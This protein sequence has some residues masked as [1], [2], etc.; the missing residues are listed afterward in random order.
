ME[1]RKTKL[2]DCYEIVP[3]RFGDSRGYFTPYYIKENMEKEGLDKIFGEIVQCNRSLSSKGTLRGLHFQLDPYCQSKVVEV[4]SGKA[5]DV[6]VD[7][8]TNSSTFG[9]N[10]WVLL[11]PIVGNQLLVPKGFAHGF[12]A[13]EDNT[14]FQYLVDNKYAP[15]YEDGITWNDEELGINWNEWF[16]KYN[17]DKPLLSDKDLKM[18]TLSLK[19]KKGN[20]KF[21]R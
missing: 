5:I 18:D 17:I 12:L 3:D 15:K 10:T 7:C 20:I 8:R 11:D 2:N 16:K 14:L 1:F 19:L 4:I 9:Q 6:V 21:K 13:I